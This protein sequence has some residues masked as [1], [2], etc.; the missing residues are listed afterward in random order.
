MEAY[1]PKIIHYSW[2]G[3]KEKSKFI[4]RCIGTWKKY[5]PDY[6]IIAWNE[7]NFDLDSHRFAK[8]A[9]EAGKYAFVS[10]YV[11]V[12]VIYHYGGIYFDTDI[13]VKK[14]FTDKLLGAKFVIAFE[15][16][17]SLMTGFFAA[18]KEN[19]AV[20]EILDYYDGIGFYSEDGS[21]KLTPN[22]VIF[23]RET[24]K[25]GLEFNGQY[26]E[27]GDGMRIY[28][29]EVF[30]GY[31]VYDMIYTITDRTV[32]VHHYTASWRTV[33][34]E[35]P[36]KLKKLLLKIFGV[37]FFRFMRRVKHRL[38]GDKKNVSK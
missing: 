15:L 29:N 4:R 35:I 31:N 26:Q 10:D 38:L 6:D 25:F 30:G 9:Y 20:K 37:E 7:T 11:R 14:D 36:V 12:Y 21:M 1:I 18:Q 34:E 16:P 22:P 28:P 23:A 33:R 3:G 17:H 13:E 32:L 24:A 27:I 2:F 19:A 5:L 8:E